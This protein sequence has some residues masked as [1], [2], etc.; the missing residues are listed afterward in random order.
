MSRA[1]LA[2]V[3]RLVDVRGK[4][5]D[6]RLVELNQSLARVEHAISQR[7]QAQQQL[8]DA[9]V[10][11]RN[12]AMVQ[13]GS[14]DWVLAQNWYVAQQALVE[15][16]ERHIAAERAKHAAAQAAVSAARVQVKQVESLVDRARDELRQADEEAEKKVEAE[17]AMRL[18]WARN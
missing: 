9:K 16:M 3:R 4:A 2:R 7:D 15:R 10:R 18:S 1:R 11:V 14:D 8:L 17:F 5:L 12:L 13:A 6:Q